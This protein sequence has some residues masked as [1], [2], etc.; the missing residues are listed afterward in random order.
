M[1]EKVEKEKDATTGAAI[2]T[3]V[4]LSVSDGTATVSDETVSDEKKP[5]EKK[6][7]GPA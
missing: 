1:S 3:E 6:P 2:V 4:F 5:D 7:D